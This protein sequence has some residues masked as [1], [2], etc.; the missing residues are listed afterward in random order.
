[1]ESLL[2]FIEANT[3]PLAVTL[4]I[5]P[6]FLLWAYAYLA[7]A[8][9]LKTVRRVKTGYT[10]KAFHVLTFLTAATAPAHRRSALCLL[11][12]RDDDARSRLCSVSG[13]GASAL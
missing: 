9:Y 1:M 12:R 7:L 11:V 2:R 10:R 5:G 3:L 6:I 4:T 8:G 13:R